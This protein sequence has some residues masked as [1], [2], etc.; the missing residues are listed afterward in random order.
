MNQQSK[1]KIKIF[2]LASFLN[3]MGSDI[4]YPVWP[5]FVRSLGADMTILGF[6]DGLGDALVSI[7]QAISGYISDRIQ[8]RK[9]FIWLGYLFGSL[10]RIGYAISTAWQH[11]IPF[12][13]LDRSGKIRSSPR[14]AMIADL[15]TDEDRGRN[16]GFLRAMDNLGAVFGI[17]LCIFLVNILGFK[18]LFLFASIPSLIGVFLILAFI[19]EEK[20]GTKIFRGISFSGLSKSFKKF[21]FLS[22]VFSLG[23]FSYS[24]LLIFAKE[25]GFKTS[26]VPVLY[27]VFTLVASPSSIPFGRLSDKIGR[28]KVLEISFLLWVIV[29]FLFLIFKNYF[30]IIFAFIFYGLHKGAIEP[31]QR[32]FVSELVPIEIRASALG[33]FQ[34]INGLFAL[35][36]SF[37]AGVLWDKISIS[38]P[39]YFSLILTLIS[40]IL[41][42]KLKSE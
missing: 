22:A 11:L 3:D 42:L 15:S 29:C 20:R 37:L 12:R 35:P 5:L 13:I 25:F 4:I 23:A 36:A 21:L 28:K 40:L 18:K 30:A 8:K 2:G 38:A 9:I 39:F 41:L 19:K 34:M 33:G 32:V 31:S 7:S 26:F 17:L 14:D 10:S 1:K 24:F 16:F 27:L 6:L